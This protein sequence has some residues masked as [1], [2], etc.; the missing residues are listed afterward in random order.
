[1]LRVLAP[2]LA[3]YHEVFD[4]KLGELP[5]VQQMRST[6]VMKQLVANPAVPV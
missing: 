4:G 5:G 3:S 6:L 2:N 1:M